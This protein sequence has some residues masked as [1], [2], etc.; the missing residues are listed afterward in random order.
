[1]KIDSGV[2]QTTWC[3][4]R[5]AEGASA[6]QAHRKRERIVSAAR[7][8]RTRSAIAGQARQ[9]RS[10]LNS[11]DLRVSVRAILNALKGPRGQS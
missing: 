6:A 4:R 10:A 8:H 5:D 11:E 2:A 3:R 7:L 9:K 1:M